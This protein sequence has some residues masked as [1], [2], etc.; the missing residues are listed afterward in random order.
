MKLEQEKVRTFHE[1]FDL[2]TAN[3]PRSLTDPEWGRRYKLI[4]EELGEYAEAAAND[5]LVGV[6]D[7][8]C[9]L[10]YVVLGTAVEHGIDIAP[11]FEEVHRSNMTKVGGYKN[12]YGKWVKGPNYVRPE[13]EPIIE[14]QLNAS[15]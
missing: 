10:L 1:T 15:T 3:S 4:D 14:E 13:L 2:E 7:A 5:D 12:E 8:I 6:A 11:C 9:D